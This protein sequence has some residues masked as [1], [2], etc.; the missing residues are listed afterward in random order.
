MTETQSTS[1]QPLNPSTPPVTSDVSELAASQPTGS[2]GRCLLYGCLATFTGGMFLILCA[3]FGTYMYLTNQVQNFTSETPIA[4]PTV[5]I[6][7]Q[8]AS[9]LESRLE[10]FVEAANNLEEETTDQDDAEQ[11]VAGEA[12]SVDSDA[13]VREDRQVEA[14]EPMPSTEQL[15]DAPPR[16]PPELRLT[17]TDLNTLV[18]R[19]PELK[20]KLFVRIENGIVSGDFSLPL[21]DWLP[22]GQGR[23]FNGSGS[24]DVRLQ[25]DVLEV[26]LVDA[27]VGDQP[28]PAPLLSEIRK[29]NLAIEFQ[30]DPRVRKA[31]K[32]YQSI[33]VEGDR[34]VLTLKPKTT[35]PSK[36]EPSSELN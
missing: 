10:V 35:K 3:G 27:K 24:F 11:A 1:M 2:S 9:E 13:I 18:T 29:K 28:I 15:A 20:D 34:L 30:K 7:E 8:K 17:A 19:H 16:K 5:E 4:M 31:L 26:N 36:I 21:D 12:I 6:D 33:A 23:F 25:D 22:G 32:A 14:D